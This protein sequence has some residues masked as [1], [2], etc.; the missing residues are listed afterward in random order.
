M[1]RDFLKGF[2]MPTNFEELGLTYED[3]LTVMK[4]ARDTRKGRYTILDEISLDD[5]NLRKLYEAKNS[6][7]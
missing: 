4:T 5:E 1:I 2:G 3:Y 6:K 7:S